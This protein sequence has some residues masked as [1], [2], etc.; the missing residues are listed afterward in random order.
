M[1]AHY[2]A[3]VAIGALLT[4]SAQTVLAVAFVLWRWR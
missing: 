2:L 3:G 4:L 1:M